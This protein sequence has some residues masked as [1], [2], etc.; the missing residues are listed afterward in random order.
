MVRTT[1]GFVDDTDLE[2][3]ISSVVRDVKAHHRLAPVDRF[4]LECLHVRDNG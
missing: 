2:G 4:T 1:M 3:E